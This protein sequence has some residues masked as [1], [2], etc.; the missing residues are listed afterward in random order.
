MDESVNEK[1][2][3]TKKRH[4]ETQREFLFTERSRKKIW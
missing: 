1:F 4:V 3:K 2:Q